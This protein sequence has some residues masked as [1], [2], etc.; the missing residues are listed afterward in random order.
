[1][2]EREVARFLQSKGMEI[3]ARNVHFRDGEVDLVARDGETLVFVEVK[4]RSSEEFGSGVEAVT[5][6]KRRRIIRG[7][8]RF[9]ARWGK[10][11]SCRFDIVEVRLDNQGRPVSFRHLKGAFE[12][13]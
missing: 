11:V 5:L 10:E 9:M 12:E 7:A 3:V 1:M 4:A 13:E 8:L 6:P 2:A